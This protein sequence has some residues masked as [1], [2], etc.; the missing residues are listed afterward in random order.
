MKNLLVSLGIMISS[1]LQC[2]QT[3]VNSA[4]EVLTASGILRGISDG[5]WTV[6]WEF[7]MPT[8]RSAN[9]AGARLNP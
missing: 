9:F 4:P 8:H 3:A 1:L 7:P 2:Q 6:F 5:V